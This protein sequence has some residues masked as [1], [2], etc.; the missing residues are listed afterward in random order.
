MDLFDYLT[1]D[2]FEGCSEVIVVRRLSIRL[3]VIIYHLS[4]CSHYPISRNSIEIC[5]KLGR[6]FDVTRE[7]DPRKILKFDTFDV[8]REGYTLAKF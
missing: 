5:G 2:V 3:R 7:L 8:I 6:F 4:L 1:M